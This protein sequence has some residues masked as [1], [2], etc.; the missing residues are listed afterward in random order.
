MPPEYDVV[1]AVH[2][3]AHM[4]R[5]ALHSIAAQSLKPQ[6]IIVVDDGSTDD[7]REALVSNPVPVQLCVQR[8]SGQAA[9]LNSGLALCRAPLVSFLDHDDLWTEDHSLL[10]INK[11]DV[12]VDLVRGAVINRFMKNDGGHHDVFMGPAR[13]LSSTM[14]RLSSTKIVGPFI[15]DFKSHSIID[16]WSRA[17]MVGLRMQTVEEPVHIRR[18]HGGN[19][20]LSAASQTRADLLSRVRDHRARSA[21][22]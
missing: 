14:I 11:M 16:W 15:E 8:H 19:E 13:L 2:N 10:L 12:D 17:M 7:L 20:G 22:S 5:D 3:G 18:I 21:S 1:I 6:Q 9:A 4:I